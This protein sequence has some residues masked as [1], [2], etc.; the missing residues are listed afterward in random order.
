M[1]RHILSILMTFILVQ[2]AGAEVDKIRLSWRDDPATTMVIGFCP[3]NGVAH[4]LRYD[5]VARP[6][7]SAAFASRMQ[8]PVTHVFAYPGGDNSKDADEKP[9]VSHFFRLTGLQPDTVYYFVIA[10]SESIS[11]RFSFRTAPAGKTPFTFIA[12]G[13]SRSNRERRRDG[14]KIVPKLRPLFVLFGGD[15]SNKGEQQQWRDWLDDW[16]LTVSED[17]RCYPIVATHGNHENADSTMVQKVFDCESADVFYTRRFGDLLSVTTLNTE[18]RHM[19]RDEVLEEQTA[20]LKDELPKLT[21]QR[22]RLV[23]YHRPMRP[24]TSRKPEGEQFYD[25]YARLFHQ[26]GIDLIVESDTH[27]VKRTYPVRPSDEAGSS[28][29]FIRDDATGMVFIGEGSWGAPRRPPDDD[30]PWTMASESFFQFKW[31]QVTHQDMQI[32]CVKFENMAN[33]QPLK[34]GAGFFP[35][36]GLKVWTPP[37]GEI[38]R[39]PFDAAHPTFQPPPV[40]QPVVNLGEQWRW[41]DPATADVKDWQSQDFDFSKWQA[42]TAPAGYGEEG[43]ATTFVKRPLTAYFQKTF[44]AP[45]KPVAAVVEL[46]CDDGAVVYLNGM[47]VHRFNMP[48]GKVEVSTRAAS[49]GEPAWKRFEIIPDQ[50]RAGENVI[51]VSVHQ[52]KESSS[53]LVFDARLLIRR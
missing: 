42:C 36:R 41:I 32:R 25:N 9:L 51:T 24:H 10:D 12:G 44:S 5:T 20:W 38:L 31:I 28:E 14:N 4:Q 2:S 35:P 21:S 16:Q 26:H 18:L 43:L 47:E 50:L 40:M 15:Y 33:I 3:V 6:A 11:K 52:V 23:A 17:G 34:D 22:W 49:R 53:D 39:L 19:G 37:T 48:G 45:F 27:M 8:N 29:G 7:D 1:L 46:F 30:K 13:D